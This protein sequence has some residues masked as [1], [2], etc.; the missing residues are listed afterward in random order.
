MDA[1]LSEVVKFDGI[2][3]EEA[4]ILAQS[5]MFFQGRARDFDVDNPRWLPDD[6]YWVLSFKSVRR[7]LADVIADK[8]IVIMIDKQS[9]AVFVEE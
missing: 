6:S 3:Q 4:L 9:G 1:Y 8:A 7:T 5:Q 2:N